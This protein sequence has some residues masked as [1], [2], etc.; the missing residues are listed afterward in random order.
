MKARELAA[1]LSWLRKNSKDLR[2][3]LGGKEDI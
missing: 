3:I 1:V 2:R